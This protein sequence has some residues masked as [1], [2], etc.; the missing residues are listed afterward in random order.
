MEIDW[1]RVPPNIA[2]RLRDLYV[3]TPS[4]CWEWQRERNG[5]GYGVC[6]PEFF[7]VPEVGFRK[8]A[9]AKRSKRG[10]QMRALAHR[11]SYAQNIGPIPDGLI[12]RHRCDNPPCVNP[13]HLELGTRTDNAKDRVERGRTKFKLRDTCKRGHDLTDSANVRWNTYEHGK[14][15]R[16]I[17]C[18]LE[19]GERKSIPPR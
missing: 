6:N 16:C 13:A 10:Y 8:V 11:V 4:G 5:Q 2:P 3:V 14:R 15:R 19:R 17:V 12:V 18:E 7:G 9:S 1:E